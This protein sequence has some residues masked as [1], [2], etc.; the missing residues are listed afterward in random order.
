MRALFGHGVFT[1]ADAQ[2][3]GATLAAYTS[4]SCHS[5]CCAAIGDVSGARRYRDPGQGAGL[6]VAVN[7]GLKVL[8]MKR[9]AQ[10]GLAL[11]TSIGVWINLGLMLW[12][13]FRAG[14]IAFDERL[15][16]SIAKLL[17]AARSLRLRAGLVNRWWRRSSGSCRAFAPS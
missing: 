9:L 7:V 14:L 17:R 10:V 1:A 3:A 2:A 15:K 12:F 16:T 6:G 5:C 13:A 4:G 8:L 11:A